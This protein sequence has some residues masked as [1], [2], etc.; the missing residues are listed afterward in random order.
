MQV[1]A[2]LNALAGGLF[3]LCTFGMVATRQ[4]RGCLRLFIGQG[5]F[6]AASAFLLSAQLHSWHIFAVGVVN[7]VSKPIL[8]PWLLRR[9][10]GSEIET[11]REIDQAVNVPTSLLIAL[12]LAIAAYFLARPLVEAAGTGHAGVNL[13]IGLAGLLV[14]AYTATVR[15]EALP[16]LLGLLAMENSAFLAGI[17]IVP[18]PPLIAELA[19]A[20]DVLILAFIVG[21]LTRAIQQNIGTTRVGELAALKEE[22]KP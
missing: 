5:F 11:R 16:L 1:L 3:L 6:L 10:V 20:S 9:T 18:D 4:V 13:P 7:I 8:I 15:R 2:N 12:A 17:A 19:I 21:V 14:G 22:A